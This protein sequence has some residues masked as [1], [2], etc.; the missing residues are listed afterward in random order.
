MHDLFYFS[1]SLLSPGKDRSHS[2]KKQ[3]PDHLSRRESILPCE[4][5]ANEEVSTEGRIHMNVKNSS[6][7]EV[8]DKIKRQKRYGQL[9]FGELKK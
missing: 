5:C 8:M 6:K 9:V 1:Q 3:C 2:R 4:T 7:D